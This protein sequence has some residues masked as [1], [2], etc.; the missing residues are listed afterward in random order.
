[1]LVFRIEMGHGSETQLQEN[2]NYLIIYRFKG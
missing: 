2:V 1:M